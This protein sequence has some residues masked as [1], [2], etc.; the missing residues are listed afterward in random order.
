MLSMATLDLAE[1]VRYVT[2]SEGRRVGV[3]L[4]IGTWESL[5]G[6]IE[7]AGLIRAIQDAEGEEVLAPRAAEE[8]YG[9]LPK[10]P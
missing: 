9:P 8:F 10:A 5:I 6:W 7:N 1:A 3:L 4:D 2:D